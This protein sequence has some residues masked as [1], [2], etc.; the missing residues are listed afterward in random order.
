MSDAPAHPPQERG[1]EVA[2]ISGRRIALTAAGLVA[3]LIVVAL[4][5]FAVRALLRPDR[6]S[7]QL[8]ARASH[9]LTTAPQLQNA[10]ALDLDALH[11]EKSAMLNEYRW[12]DRSKGVVQIPIERA[13]QLTIE[14][15]VANRSLEKRT[16]PPR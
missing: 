8:P 4:A 6:P 1:H 12:I 13:M 16:E 15:S 7:T 5:A 14:R 9:P 10:P 3:V 11:R 2:D